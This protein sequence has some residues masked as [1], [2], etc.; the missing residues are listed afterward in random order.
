MLETADDVRQEPFLSFFTGL[1]GVAA[2]VLTALAFS[3]LLGGL[4]WAP[5]L[6]LVALLLVVLKLW[7]MVAVFY[8]LGD[9]VAQRLLHRSLRPLN[10]A[11]L[12]LLLMGGVKF[13]PFVGVWVWTAATLIGIGATLTTKFGRREVWFDFA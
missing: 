3:I 12:G 13:L 9:W 6:A 2:L 8:A 7:G 5:M 10:A 11:T 4:T 1:T